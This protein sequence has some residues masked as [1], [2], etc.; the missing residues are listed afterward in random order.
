MSFADNER[1]EKAVREAVGKLVD[2]QEYIEQAGAS[3]KFLFNPIYAG[4]VSAENPVGK[5]YRD[6]ARMFVHGDVAKVLVEMGKILADDEQIEVLEAL[7]TAEIHAEL[8]KTSEEEEWDK[9]LVPDQGKSAHTSG[10]MAVDIAIVKNEV[11][12]DYGVK[13]NDNSSKELYRDYT[14]H[15]ITISKEAFANREFLDDLIDR[16]AEA[17]GVEIQKHPHE[18]FQFNLPP[19]EYLNAPV[20]HEEDLPEKM[21]LASSPEHKL[22]L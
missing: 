9:N 21:R 6:G 17:A 14:L 11:R 3:H 18:I 1:S 12:V 7:R 5:I 19:H 8:T 4:D 15:E 10:G 2:L 22:G 16:G 20:L 13:Y